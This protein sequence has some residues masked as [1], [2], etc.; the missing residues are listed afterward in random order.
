MCPQLPHG[1]Y[2][3]HRV[4]TFDLDEV[5]PPEQPVPVHVAESRT[6]SVFERALDIVKNVVVIITCVVI[7]I[8]LWDAYSFINHLQ[9]ALQDLGNHLTLGG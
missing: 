8:A 4:P 3:G 6:T 5:F 2:S 1:D 9:K 7:L